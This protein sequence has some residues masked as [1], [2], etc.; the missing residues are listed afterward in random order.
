MVLA[1]VCCGNRINETQIM[2][3]SAAALSHSPLTMIVFT[4]DELKPA[5]KQMVSLTFSRSLSLVFL[6]YVL[7][8]CVW[9][10]QHKLVLNSFYFSD[11]FM[12]KLCFTVTV[13]DTSKCI[14]ESMYLHVLLHKY[15][16]ICRTSMNEY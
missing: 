1:V 3:K 10:L 7:L 14:D 8:E 16:Q 2:L 4:E 5:F 15:T 11:Y 13:Y 12:H 6:L 9:C